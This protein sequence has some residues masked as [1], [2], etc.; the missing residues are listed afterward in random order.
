[1]GSS[2]LSMRGNREKTLDE[3]IEALLH[4]VDGELVLKK[5]RGGACYRV[6]LL[7]FEKYYFRNGSYA[8]LTVMVT[9]DGNE[10]IADIIGS[11]GG[12]GI[13]NFSWGANTDF[14][15]MAM[16]VLK[17]VGFS[18]QESKDAD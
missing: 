10:Q 8:N 18:V 17:T 15:Y 6:G 9:D 16:E 12:E 7:V 3:V 13:F 2:V 11:G 5:V 1:M 4:K 14:S